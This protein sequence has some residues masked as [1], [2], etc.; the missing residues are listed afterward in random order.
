MHLPTSAG[1]P[2]CPIGDIIILTYRLYSQTGKGITILGARTT[3]WSWNWAVL[4]LLTA[5]SLHGNI[6]CRW[7]CSKTWAAKGSSW[8]SSTLGYSTSFALARVISMGQGGQWGTAVVHM[9]AL[10]LSNV[11]GFTSSQLPLLQPPSPGVHGCTATPYGL[12]TLL[13][14]PFPSTV[15]QCPF[16]SAF[17]QRL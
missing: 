6:S 9:A 4:E 12:V 2:R 11:R 5:W 3:T 10:C 13:H 7:L 17:P 16:L 15:I 8:C 14:S 1:E